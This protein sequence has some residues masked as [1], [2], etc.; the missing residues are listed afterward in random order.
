MLNILRDIE[1]KRLEVLHADA[2]KFN[3]CSLGESIKVVSNLPYNMASLI[4][5]NI[6]LHHVCIPMGILMFQK[7][8]ALR[9]AGKGEISWLSVFL[10]AVYKVEYKMSV[11]PRFFRPPP[12]VQSGVLK[13]S[14]RDDIRISDLKDFKD[15]LVRLFANR[16]KRLGGKLEERIL[17]AVG[18]DPNRRVDSLEL[19]EF[20]GLYRMVKLLE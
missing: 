9:L 11:P 2:S 17:K 6:I 3:F 19:E 7:E 15:F 12:R 4:L 18:I 1:D 16:R 13:I 5:E 20:I 8:V 14:R 10:R